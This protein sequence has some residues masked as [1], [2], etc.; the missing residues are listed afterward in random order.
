[1]CMIK[2]F[3]LI[4]LTFVCYFSKNIVKYQKKG[5]KM[6]KKVKRMPIIR[7]IWCRI[8]Q[9]AFRVIMP[10][11]P[12]REPKLL[13]DYSQ[14]SEV[15]KQNNIKKVLVITSQSLAKLGL[16]EDITKQLTNQNIE[17][18]IFDK[19]KP[20]PTISI[21]E[22]ALLEY[23]QNK[24]QG[25]I[26]FGGGSVMDCAKVLGARAVKPKQSI[27]K[28][29]GL[30]KIRKKL[31]LLVAI[32]TT[33]G[34]GSETTLCA[35][36]TDENSKNKYAIS[37]FCLIPQYVVLDVY[38]TL[39]LPKNLT[40]TTGMDALTHAVESYIGRST[41]AYTRKMSISAVKLIVDNLYTCYQNGQDIYARKNMLKASYMAGNAF[42][43]SYVGYVHAIAHSLGG[44]Y[45]LS[46]GLMNAIILPK[47]LKTY[48][49]SCQKKLGKLAKYVGLATP[50][51]DNKTA[52]EKFIYFIEEMNRAMIIPTKIEEIKE[53][54]I[55]IL[56]KNAERE[57]NP[58]YPV[59]KILSKDQLQQIY[60]ELKA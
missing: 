33:A 15:I 39:N 57:A 2:F 1:M 51:D 43:R 21:I 9:I 36:I 4:T 8:H 44:K 47:M 28:M 19:V 14:M 45:N 23:N 24:C 25:I 30:L 27:T 5:Q 42:S 41:T 20:N 54:D 16:I 35:V 34:T 32:P 7:K 12:Y 22:Q 10:I 38:P 37:D 50:L 52:S 60:Y 29:K 13:A 26:A 6:D 17:F 40:S 59:P 46:H 48:G 56:A 58:L 18:V 31:P 53:E 49:K 3:V 11:L 55:P